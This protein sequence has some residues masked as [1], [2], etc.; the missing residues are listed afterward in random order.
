MKEIIEKYLLDFAAKNNW[1][2]YDP[3]KLDECIKYI[4]REA[5]KQAVNG[6][7]MIEDKEV[8]GWAVH[9]YDEGGIEVNDIVPPEKRVRTVDVFDK[10]RKNIDETKTRPEKAEDEP[11]KE[12]KKTKKKVEKKPNYDQIGFDFGL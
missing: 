6:T 1:D 8:F 12:V 3:N 4:T 10:S 5:K 9:F 2:K 11:K 7:A